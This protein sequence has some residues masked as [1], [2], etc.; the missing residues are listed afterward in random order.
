MVES[1]SVSGVFRL[2]FTQ[3]RRSVPMQRLQCPLP[4]R[5]GSV[6]D[7]IGRHGDGGNP[8]EVDY[9]YHL[10]RRHGS[11]RRLYNRLCRTLE[12]QLIKREAESRQVA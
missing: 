10:R 2:Y 1:H 11:L 6:P 4:C 9:D 12:L 5:R 8:I 7:F 3:W